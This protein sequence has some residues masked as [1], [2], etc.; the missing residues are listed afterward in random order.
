MPPW[1]ANVAWV[2]AWMSIG[3]MAWMSIG[4][5]A[6]PKCPNKQFV[7]PLISLHPITHTS[8]ITPTPHGKTVMKFRHK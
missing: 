4:I 7:P 6:A 5:M 2:I 1:L 8:L 3:I